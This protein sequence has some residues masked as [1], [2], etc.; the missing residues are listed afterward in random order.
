MAMDRLEQDRLRL[1][2]MGYLNVLPIYHPLECGA[3]SH[4]FSIVSGTPAD[5][6]HLMAHGDLDIS[7]VSSIEYARHPD[8]YFILPDLSISCSG[9]VR[10]VLLLS[11]VPV[12]ELAGETIL[13]STQSHT[14]VVLL[15]IL[16]PLHFGVQATYLPGDCM[17]DVLHGHHPKAFLA[18]GDEALKLRRHSLYPFCWDLGEAWHDFTG[19]PFVFALWVAQRKAMEKWNG[20]L[21]EALDTLSACKEW[22]RAH[23]DVIS[24]EALRRGLLELEEIHDYYNCLGYDLSVDERKGLELFYGY[25]QEIGEVPEPP[26]LE[27]YSPL[28]R[29]A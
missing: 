22:S 9:A 10:S 24:A 29:V 1:G 15:K 3:I 4:S 14:S 26:R 19:L 25:L 17:R 12:S 11:R 13:V 23:S 28:S 27:I 6:N 18:I 21:K 7:V 20:Y 16:L 8:R 2:K 5:L